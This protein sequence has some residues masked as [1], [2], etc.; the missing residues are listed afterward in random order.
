MFRLSVAIIARDEAD[1]IEAALASVR[2]IADEI[3]VLDSG[4]TDDTVARARA[5]GAQV[6]CVD[7]PG[8]VE[9]KNRALRLC[10]GAWVLSIDADER[11][12]PELAQAVA[13]VVRAEP[14]G[15][16]VGYEIARLSW[17]MGAPIRHGT[18][19]PDR[20][21]RLVRRERGRW[22]GLDPHDRLQVDGPVG[23]LPGQLHHH[24][25]RSLGEHLAV[26]D[27]YTA[28]AARSLRAAGR[29]VRPVDV[30]VRPFLHFVKAYLLKAGFRDGVRGVCLAWLGASYVA[31]KW[32]R[33]RLPPDE[34]GE[35][36]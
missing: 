1:R 19:Y 3:V 29:P 26:I 2:D 25:Y 31:L 11:L 10:R 9:Q 35:P 20:R 22:A 21:L 4:S 27:R 36:A 23:V 8:H 6:H 12:D 14:P 18:W 28:I 13:A 15:P 17:W 34:R 33:A 7:W 5:A 32:A 30:L 24:P 16:L